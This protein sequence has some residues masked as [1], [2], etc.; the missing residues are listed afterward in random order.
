MQILHLQAT[1]WK[2]CV[3]CAHEQTPAQAQKFLPEKCVGDS[4][5]PGRTQ[6]R[7]IHVRAAE[8]GRT[9]CLLP[10]LP[11]YL[12]HQGHTGLL[13]MGGCGGS[14]CQ[15]CRRHSFRYLTTGY[16]GATHHHHHGSRPPRLLRLHSLP[17][18]LDS[19]A[20]LLLTVSL[21]FN[22]LISLATISNCE[23]IDASTGFLKIGF[24]PKGRLFY[25]P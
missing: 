10:Q 20:F 1:T 16:G 22:N 13:I 11:G 25:I 17:C 14:G 3:P 8:R 19:V 2:T 12:R 6:R 9:Q 23:A 4:R 5:H 18:L 15:A 21:L 7:H 24:L